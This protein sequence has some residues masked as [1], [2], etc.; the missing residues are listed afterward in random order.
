MNTA[1]W[2]IEHEIAL[3]TAAGWSKHKRFEMF[4]VLCKPIAT[5]PKNKLMERILAKGC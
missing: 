2:I 1:E 5:K 4:I 3:V